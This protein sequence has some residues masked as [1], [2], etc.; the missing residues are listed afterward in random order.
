MD[1]HFHILRV[2]LFGPDIIAGLDRLARLNN[3]RAEVGDICRESGVGTA[4][5]NTGETQL[6]IHMFCL[7]LAPSLPLRPGSTT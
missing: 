6:F 7:S 3:S 5:S 2:A 1:I 4:E